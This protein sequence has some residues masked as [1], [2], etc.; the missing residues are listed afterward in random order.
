MIGHKVF[1]YWNLNKHCWSIRAREGQRR[2]R[3]IGHATQLS[4][5][6]VDMKV[7][8]AGRQRVLET[9]R[10]NVHA[11]LAGILTGAVYLNAGYCEDLDPVETTATQQQ[12]FW[13]TPARVSY[14]PRK[15]PTF[16]DCQTGAPVYRANDAYC[17]Y[18]RNVTVWGIPA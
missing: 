6:A 5:T 4:L 15:G 12:D 7:S 1:V 16:V 8:E 18:A 14:N 3:V 17:G 10:K 11:G 2:G 13:G 9:G